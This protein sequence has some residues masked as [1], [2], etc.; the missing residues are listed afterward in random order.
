MKL[1]LINEINNL[2]D[3]TDAIKKYEV[4]KL[5]PNINK[6]K[7]IDN[8]DVVTPEDEHEID[9]P[10]RSGN[11]E[12]TP[13]LN[14]NPDQGDKSGLLGADQGTRSSGMKPGNYKV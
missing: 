8:P 2:N 4:H 6:E 9:Q 14:N 7:A 5:G 3:L 13:N 12:A 11:Q 10:Q 1:K